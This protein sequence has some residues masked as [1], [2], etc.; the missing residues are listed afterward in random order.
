[1]VESSTSNRRKTLLWRATHRG[2]RELD[3]VLGGFAREFLATMTEGELDELEALIDLPDPEL[4][5]WILGESDV[6]PEF[7]NRTTDGLL[8]YR[9]RIRS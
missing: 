5:S 4:M 3:L 2:T 1:M 9:P 7:R 6:R 8:S